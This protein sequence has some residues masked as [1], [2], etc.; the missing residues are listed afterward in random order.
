M[1][2]AI[3]VKMK[4]R[5]KKANARVNGHSTADSIRLLPNRKE[6]SKMLRNTSTPQMKKKI[7]D[8]IQSSAAQR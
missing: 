8:H 5:K 4:M 2:E 1:K 6:K 7:N 3:P